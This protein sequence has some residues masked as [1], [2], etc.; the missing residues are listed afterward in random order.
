LHPIVGADLSLEPP[1][2]HAAPASLLL[3]V[4]SVEGY[5]NLCRLLTLG[6]ARCAKGE[7][8]VDWEE[9][10]ARSSGLVAL[11]RG[12][13][14]L[15]PALLER[16]RACFGRG[17]LFVDV[18]RTLSRHAEAASRRAVA[19]AEAAGIPIVAA[20][21]VRFAAPADRPQFDARTCLRHKTTRDRAGRRSLAAAR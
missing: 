19:V 7:S 2:A 6:H 3:L 8:R 11:A 10:E 16:A 4:E 9:L 21:D 12:D 1:A 15:V 5:R 17:R 18:S 13:A 20:G 14:A